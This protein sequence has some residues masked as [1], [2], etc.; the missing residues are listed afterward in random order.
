MAAAL[1]RTIEILRPTLL[2]AEADTYLGNNEDLRGVINSGHRRNGRVIRCVGDSHEPR[3]FSTWAPVLLAQIG[4]PPSTVYDR[5]IV[6][7]LRRKK[8]SERAEPFSVK[9][10]NESHL[11]ARQ[12]ARWTRDCN[13]KIASVE[14]ISLGSQNDRAN[15]NWHPLFAVAEAAGGQWPQR[16]RYAA[17]ML[18]EGAGH[19]G[20]AVE[21]MLIADIFGIF[22][23][24]PEQGA[25]GVARQA[26]ERISSAD[27]V[28]QLAAIEGR[29]WAEWRHG[30]ALTQNALAKLLKEFKITPG[31][32]RVPERNTL[33]GYLRSDFEDL[34]ERYGLSQTVTPSQPSK[35]SNLAEIQSVTSVGDVTDRKVEKPNENNACYGVTVGEEAS[36][37]ETVWTV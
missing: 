36:R 2:L 30:K 26:L 23:G 28:E 20:A 13:A 29:P 18:V 24:G 16:A 7:S 10:R 6:I 4:T 3:Q 32:I 17:A 21:E 25:E 5:S 35:I 37:E 9:G 8:P 11:L 27:L 33:K 31:T 1:F 34:F 12:A 22:E 14:P 15:D 19:D